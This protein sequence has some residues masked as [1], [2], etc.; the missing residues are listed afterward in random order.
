MGKYILQVRVE[1]QDKSSPSITLS[2]C[3]SNAGTQSNVASPQSNKYNEN[4]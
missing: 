1:K 3:A 4:T 2:T